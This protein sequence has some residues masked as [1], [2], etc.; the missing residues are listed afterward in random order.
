MMKRV[1]D[2][3]ARARD[4]QSGVT[5]VEMI[6]VMAMLTII[7][8]ALVTV[9]VSGLSAQADAV[10]SLEAQTEAR[11]AADRLRREVHCASS[12]TEATTTVTLT[13]PAACG[14]GT[15]V[16]YRT[17]AV[18]ANRFRLLRAGIQIADHLT[19]GNVF[20]YQPPTT[21]ELGRLRVTLPVN[22]APGDT[23][24]DWRLQDEVVLRNSQRVN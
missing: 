1:R 12:M 21:D 22:V 19:D 20:S 23:L 2:L 6:T 15:S 14:T 7:V 11:G 16:E 18:A 8:G 5:L 10:R 17:E 4:E 24:T 9:F 13:L 3:L